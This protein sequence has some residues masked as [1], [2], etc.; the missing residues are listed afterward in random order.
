MGREREIN[1]SDMYRD[2]SDRIRYQK[3]GVSQKAPGVDFFNPLNVSALLEGWFY[4]GISH[5]VVAKGCNKSWTP[6]DLIICL[7]GPKEPTNVQ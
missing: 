2:E 7:A 1:S 5:E 6:S 4:C 3:E